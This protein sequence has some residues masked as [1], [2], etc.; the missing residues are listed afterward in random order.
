[1]VERQGA[2][3]TPGCFRVDNRG[4]WSHQVAL[5]SDPGMSVGESDKPSS[6]VVRRGPDL[7]SQR[8]RAVV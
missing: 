4:V 5:A 3:T 2:N 8:V 7:K 6:G 1:M